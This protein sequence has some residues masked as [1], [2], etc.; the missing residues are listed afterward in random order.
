MHFVVAFIELLFIQYIEFL[1]IEEK[2]F[3]SKLKK[4]LHFI[5]IYIYCLPFLNKY[6]NNQN[7]CP[8]EIINNSILPFD[9]IGSFV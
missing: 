3:K 5:H 8:F 2:T 1:A 4:K 7:S 9:S 6:T